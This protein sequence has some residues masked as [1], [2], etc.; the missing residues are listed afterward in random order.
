MN[1]SYFAVYRGNNGINIAIKPVTGFKGPSYPEL[2]PQ[3]SFLLKYKE[4]GDEDAY[5]KEYYKLVLNRLD[6]NKV[7]EELKDKTLL[8]WER[9][10]TFCHRRIVAGWIENE[11]G[12][13]VP[14]L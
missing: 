9:R 6:P 3:W 5:T 1:T 11:T 8:C 14:E 7:Y 4:D 2:Y 13:I 12:M 10:G